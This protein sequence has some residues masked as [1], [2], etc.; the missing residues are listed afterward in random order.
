MHTYHGIQ[1][2]SIDYY[3]Y[4][5]EYD[6]QAPV[7]MEVVSFAKGTDVFD[8]LYPLD[9][10]L[11]TERYELNMTY[12]GP[13]TDRLSV[14]SIVN[15]VV[16]FPLR[17]TYLSSHSN[18]CLRWNINTFFDFSHRGRMDV[19]VEPTSRL[20]DTEL[21]QP[22]YSR[23]IRVEILLLSSIAILA[24][25]SQVLHFYSIIVSFR[26][27]QDAERQLRDSRHTS[28]NK[29]PCNKKM[30]FFNLWFFVATIGNSCN[31]IGAISG[32]QFGITGKEINGLRLL[33]ISI[34]CMMAWINVVQYFEFSLSYYVLILTLKKGT[35]RVL[36]FLIGVLPVFFG[37]CLFGFALFSSRSEKFGTVD[38]SA[39]TLFSLLNGDSIYDVFEELYP[40]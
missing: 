35:P 30:R 5:Y 10:S 36:R 33:F 23:E 37:Y 13:I 2:T 14:Y 7:V 34:G 29:L 4:V 17:N 6:K 19:T 28:W 1:N 39:V 20:C 27:L 25:I 21:E 32:I 11:K 9:S 38:N 24:A 31:I 22:W 12:F 16:S 40:V 8:P 26:A 3:E 15:M 18:S